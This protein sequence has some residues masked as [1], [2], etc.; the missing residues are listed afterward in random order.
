MDTRARW[1]PAGS[2]TSKPHLGPLIAAVCLAGDEDAGGGSAFA[3]MAHEAKDR[4]QQTVAGV[5]SQSHGYENGQKK[6]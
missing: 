3:A 4:H 2:A 1:R 5:D 6:C